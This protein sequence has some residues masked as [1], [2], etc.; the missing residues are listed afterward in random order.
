MSQPQPTVKTVE[1]QVQYLQNTM[2]ENIKKALNRGDKLDDLENRT[3]K[4][5]ADASQ[6]NRTTKKTKSK[7]IWKNRKWTMILILVIATIILLV[8]LAIVLLAVFLT[9]K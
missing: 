3:E 6:F 1:E 2:R 7:F 5:D 8:I 9:K 4:L